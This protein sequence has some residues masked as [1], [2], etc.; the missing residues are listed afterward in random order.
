MTA[1]VIPGANLVVITETDLTGSRVSAAEGKGW[2]A[3][4]R[5]HQ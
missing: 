2:R 3:K 5:K 4:R 1:S